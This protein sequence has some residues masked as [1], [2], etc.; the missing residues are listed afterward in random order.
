MG[1][2]CRWR[3]GGAGRLA[4]RSG[5]CG[6]NHE[7]GG[8]YFVFEMEPFVDL[9]RTLAAVWSRF[10]FWA[11]KLPFILPSGQDAAEE[12]KENKC[13]SARQAVSCVCIYPRGQVRPRRPPPHPHRGSSNSSPLRHLR[14]I[15]GSGAQIHLERISVI[16]AS[17]PR[18]LQRT[19]ISAQQSKRIGE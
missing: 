17:G 8:G 15:L 14:A 5:G 7:H 12:L 9:F 6:G 19:P 2:I 13:G 11:W 10:F 1:L 3:R 18:P 4:G 16:S